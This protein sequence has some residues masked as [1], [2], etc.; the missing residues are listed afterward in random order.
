MNN[1]FEVTFVVYVALDG[2][3]NRTNYLY[4]LLF[5]HQEANVGLKYINILAI[6]RVNIE[7]HL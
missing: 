3:A 5:C 4:K 7:V 2:P 1:H 6:K